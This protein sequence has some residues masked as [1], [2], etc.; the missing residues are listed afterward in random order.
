MLSG[1]AVKKKK[2]KKLRVAFENE[3]HKT[4]RCSQ[5]PERHYENLKNLGRNTA[6]NIHK[7]CEIKGEVIIRV[8][9]RRLLE[10]VTASLQGTADSLG[11]SA[12]RHLD[13]SSVGAEVK[14]LQ[15]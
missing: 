12:H 14:Q 4:N 3:N 15:Q 13:T 5:K 9:K 6:P 1:R 8:R 2:K 11:Q 7:F 10:K